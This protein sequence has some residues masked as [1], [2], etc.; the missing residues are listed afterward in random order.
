MRALSGPLTGQ[1]ANVSYGS[2]EKTG[3]MLEPQVRFGPG[4]FA[5]LQLS[6][7]EHGPLEAFAYDVIVI[8]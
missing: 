3:L 7:D 5:V 4:V 8:P 1:D 6:S 2:K